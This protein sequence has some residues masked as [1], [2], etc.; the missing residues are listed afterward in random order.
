MPS[1]PSKPTDSELEILSFLWQ[2]GPSTVRQ[3]HDFLAK[4]KEA[5]YTTT[6]KLMQIMQE[7]GLLSRTE[8]GR[9][10]IYTAQVSEEE[11]QQSLLGR[12]VETAFRGSAAQLVMQALGTHQTSAEEL[13]EIRQL[14]DN[15]ENNR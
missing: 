15:L 8:E 3:V 13:D 9:S 7:K 2:H 10:H 5:G 11:T 14:L 4:T 12:F 6:L 1:N